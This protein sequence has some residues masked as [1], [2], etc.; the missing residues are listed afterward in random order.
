MPNVSVETITFRT[1]NGRA[2]PLLME[3]PPSMDRQPVGQPEWVRGNRSNP[4]AYTIP[5]AD[6]D[7]AI[8]VTFSSADLRDAATE[9]RALRAGGAIGVGGIKQTRVTFDANGGTEPTEL[10]MELK[11]QAGVGVETV[12]WIWQVVQNAGN[13][14]EIDVDRTTQR[15]ALVLADPVSPWSIHQS[16]GRDTTP[17]W[18]VLQLAC[19]AAV[20]SRTFAEAANNITR[21]VYH[22][23]GSSYY[24]YGVSSNYA[25]GYD[26]PPDVFDCARF[27]KLLNGLPEPQLVDCAD[28]A[29]IVKTF[30]A[31]LG[32]PASE[33]A[34][35]GGNTRHLLM[36]GNVEWRLP[37]RFGLHE[38]VV[39]EGHS[40]I[41]D[42]CLELSTSENATPP[43]SPE[44]PKEIASDN[45]LA[46][47]FEGPGTL[48]DLEQP[49]VPR[50]IG[51]IGNLV[52]ATEADA[53]VRLA[54]SVLMLEMRR[55]PSMGSD[56]RIPQINLNNVVVGGWQLIDPA[57]AV[58]TL[59]R[60]T[61]VE[62]VAR[63]VWRHDPEGALMA[64]DVSLCTD[65]QSARLRT[66][67]ILG[68][69]LPF[70]PRPVVNA[71]REEL[72]FETSDRQAIVATFLNA[73]IHVHVASK[74]RVAPETNRQ[75]LDTIRGLMV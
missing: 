50:S 17:W 43:V 6:E 67:A 23:W 72:E 21:A 11:G 70:G 34:I 20:G 8:V 32:C 59:P 52:P 10:K 63:G 51:A 1:P 5:D 65:A 48:R 60:D 35:S 45:Y 9:I 29:A 46:G 47:V 74:V 42:A 4:V 71:P 12:E 73:S 57:Q 58:A 44:L 15:I 54:A 7:I 39:I 36:V 41:W 68:R 69:L 61:N 55:G 30:T 38:F 40:R 14:R 53:L 18:D 26:T 56:R 31:I 16:A 33:K 64:C 27:L 28:T 62:S 25:T 22:V 19:D 13:P 2:L 3:Q 49:P 75:F 24:R 37:N 66:L